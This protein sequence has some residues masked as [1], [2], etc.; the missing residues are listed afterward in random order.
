MSIGFFDRQFRRQVAAGDFVLNPFEEAALPRLAGRVLDYG[1][2]LGNL[3]IA[4]ARRGCTV[5][6]LDGSPTA[7]ERIR[8][9]AAAEGL[10]IDAAV[11]DLRHQAPTG[12]FDCVVS[13]GL[14]AFFDCGTARARLADLQACVRPG[15]V[16]SINTLVEGTSYLDLFEGGDRCLLPRGELRRAFAGWEVV[17]EEFRDF[18]APGGTLK[19]FV[20]LTARKAG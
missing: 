15:G 2:G 11:A 20:T 10:A 9:V 19:S 13:I 4:A 17:D 14:L 16:A 1:C 3:S 12:E 6:A 7:V 5:V 18:P 8:A